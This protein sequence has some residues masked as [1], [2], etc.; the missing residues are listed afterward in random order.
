MTTTER[1]RN[2]GRLAEARDEAA[3]LR[4][5]IG[6]LRSAMRENLDEFAEVEELPLD[7]V[8]PQALEAAELAIELKEK[9]ATI[10]ALKKALGR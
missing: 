6:G 5:K 4:L 7:L 10:D 8:A 9:L 3:N 1:L 2:R